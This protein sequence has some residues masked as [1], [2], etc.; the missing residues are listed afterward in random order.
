MLRGDRAHT[1]VVATATRRHAP[2]RAVTRRHLLSSCTQTLPAALNS[3]AATMF[4]RAAAPPR[5]TPVSVAVQRVDEAA[6]NALL[7]YVVDQSLVGIHG[8]MGRLP[9][10]VVVQGVRRGWKNHLVVWFPRGGVRQL[11]HIKFAC[12]PSDD[13]A[14][15]PVSNTVTLAAPHPAHAQG[16]GVDEAVTIPFR[17][18]GRYLRWEGHAAAPADPVCLHVTLT[19]KDGATNTFKCAPT[20]YRA[21][22]VARTALC[23]LRHRTLADFL[24]A[25]ETSWLASGFCGI[26]QLRWLVS[27]VVSSR[28]L[29][30]TYLSTEHVHAALRMLYRRLQRPP[31]PAPVYVGGMR[32]LFMRDNMPADAVAD[33]EN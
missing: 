23:P 17:D 1:M 33:L 21:D 6:S 11:S 5:F 13:D 15:P 20:Y 10:Y 22:I 2:S 12:V 19:F 29:D 30:G 31:H 7:L 24:A 32:L 26:A 14:A 4:P 27:R 28:R 16:A 8:G 18:V 25:P 3:N 9:A